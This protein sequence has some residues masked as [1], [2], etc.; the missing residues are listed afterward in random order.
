[1]RFGSH[2]LGEP[3]SA[4]LRARCSAAAV[5]LAMPRKSGRKS[6]NAASRTGTDAGIAAEV[7]S[8]FEALESFQAAAAAAE[9]REHVVPG[10]LEEADEAVASSV[11][12]GEGME[13]G[14][15]DD[16]RNS[17]HDALV[18]MD[19]EPCSI[20]DVEPG[21]MR[22]QGCFEG[23]VTTH[24]H[25]VDLAV[26][27]DME[28]PSEVAAEAMRQLGS[29]SRSASPFRLTENDTAVPPPF[30]EKRS[31]FSKMADFFYR[32]AMESRG[33][34]AALP[35]L[36]LKLG[37]ET[38]LE[39]AQN[40]RLCSELE[41]SQGQVESLVEERDRLKAQV[42]MLLNEQAEQA[43]HLD[44]MRLQSE[45][46][47]QSSGNVNDELAEREEDLRELEAKVGAA[48]R[49]AEAL[50][51]DLAKETAA[52]ERIEAALAAAHAHT[53][54]LTGEKQRFQAEVGELKVKAAGLEAKVAA[55]TE[56]LAEEAAQ[57]DTET[58]QAKEGLQAK[59][60]GLGERVREFA[61]E[62]EELQAKLTVAS[63]G[64]E[65][66][67]ARIAEL[68]AN[69]VV[70]AGRAA[71]AEALGREASRSLE[72]RNAEVERLQEEAD[73]L[74][75]DLVES[76]RRAASEA[77]AAA[78]AQSLVDN[79][80]ARLEASRKEA[81]DAARMA[82]ATKEAG[83]AEAA[84]PQEVRALREKC[85]TLER[86]QEALQEDR[87]Q[88]WALREECGALRAEQGKAL[89]GQ[90]DL[91]KHREDLEKELARLKQQGSGM[92]RDLE[93]ARS[94]L[95]A[96]TAAK[97][98]SE[99][100]VSQAQ[101]ASSR[102]KKDYDELK[103]K[104][105]ELGKRE[106]AQKQ[107]ATNL[108]QELAETQAKLSAAGPKAAGR[109][110]T[111]QAQA[112]SDEKAAA[113]AHSQRL[114]ALQEVAEG[115]Q[116]ISELKHQLQR[117]EAQV[118]EAEHRA[119]AAT[120]EAQTQAQDV[121]QFLEERDKARHELREERQKGLGSE[122][123]LKE[124]LHHLRQAEVRARVNVQCLEEEIARLKSRC[125][126]YMQQAQQA[127]ETARPHARGGQL[128]V[129]DLGSSCLIKTIS[130]LAATTAGLT[131]PSVFQQPVATPMGTSS[132]RTVTYI[133]TTTQGSF[134]P[135]SPPSQGASIST[136]M[137]GAP[138]VASPLPS[139]SRV[140][141][142]VA[143]SP[144]SSF[145]APPPG[146]SFVAPPPG[147][148]FVAPSPGSSFVAQAPVPS[149]GASIGLPIGGTTVKGTATA[150]RSV[151]SLGA[152][153]VA[154]ATSSQRPVSVATM[155]SGASVST[156]VH[157]G[158]SLGP[159]RAKMNV[160]VLNVRRIRPKQ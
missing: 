130:N 83:P 151:A 24:T 8:P 92:R 134:D 156:P 78:E 141:S 116:Q 126:T 71:E 68:E 48:A 45:L 97:A 29:H 137:M 114:R 87:R 124:E 152:M 154:T 110:A 38:S 157:V 142:A 23:T 84:A 107:E 150:T 61:A 145:V 94:D 18:A 57:R 144:G 158:T 85:E 95:A 20:E 89:R 60:Q 82:A 121:A 75:Q 103:T 12:W 32:D 33:P 25:Q 30:Q 70:L 56:R 5:R 2:R 127:C 26:G 139:S 16:L 111:L 109:I 123:R 148:S 62:R 138:C 79:L 93:R 106:K 44:G 21:Q 73:L 133:G 40:R 115:N 76:R 36:Q 81:A 64:S 149:Y 49:E 125:A 46:C 122:G 34:Q 102:L 99:A 50:R 159:M 17:A 14:F 47:L 4:I 1:M 9:A 129:Q 7:T 77:S 53:E 117:K 131:G 108:S 19:E 41:A 91:V 42:D 119:E 88:L 96:A 54:A 6:A 35:D 128:T 52:R 136:S 155:S 147:N 140:A 132:G 104:L 63:E 10:S 51:G 31:I 105:M 15:I 153:P 98:S 80:T 11:A 58:S 100:L 118:V 113:E 3:Y 143:P 22:L 27:L 28:M 39:V 101:L 13:E 86:D 67:K 74:R 146:S 160:Q 120:K 43:L 69:D 65:A 135:P 72:E 90:D 37:E 55:L 66:A 112:A 59:L